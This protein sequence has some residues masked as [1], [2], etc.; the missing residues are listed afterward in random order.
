MCMDTENH[1]G[2]PRP[3]RTSSARRSPPALEALLHQ[4]SVSDWPALQH[5]LQSLPEARPEA[6]ARAR[7]LIADP[8]YPSPQEQKLLARRLAAQL[9]A[10][11]DRPPA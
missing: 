10:E 3:K 8:D 1:F 6:V 11:I 9:R 5:S 4:A 7:K 2:A